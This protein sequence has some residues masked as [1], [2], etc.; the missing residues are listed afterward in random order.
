ILLRSSSDSLRISQQVEI[1][2]LD[3]TPHRNVYLLKGDIRGETRLAVTAHGEGEV[4]VCFKNY[5]S[6]TGSTFV[7]Q[8]AQNMTCTI[9]L[10]IDI[11]A[12]VVD[13]QAISALETNMKS[14]QEIVD[15]LDHLKE[16]EEYFADVNSTDLGK[17]SSLSF[18]IRRIFDNPACAL[19]PCETTTIG[20]DV[21]HTLKK[22]LGVPVESNGNSNVGRIC[23]R[24][25]SQLKLMALW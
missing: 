24:T 22:A 4:G 19:C 1:E 5:L 3:S 25:R 8:M 17:T 16:R 7:L 13:Q 15:E 18:I 10:D 14:M 12:N 20:L 2:N 11:G 9:G 23:R 6:P 21:V